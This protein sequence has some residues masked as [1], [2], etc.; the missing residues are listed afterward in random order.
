MT[1]RSGEEETREDIVTNQQP[2]NAA[3]PDSDKH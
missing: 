3:H 1:T 2:A